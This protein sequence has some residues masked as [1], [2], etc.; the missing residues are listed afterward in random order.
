MEVVEARRIPAQY[1]APDARDANAARFGLGEAVVEN[2]A[3]PLR[4][5]AVVEDRGRRLPSRVADP[6]DG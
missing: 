5:E 1:A 3:F 6:L 4:R 2:D